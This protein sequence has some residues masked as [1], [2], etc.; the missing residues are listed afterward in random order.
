[1]RRSEVRPFE[2]RDRAWARELLTSRWGA[3]HVVARGRLH[4]ADLL[5]GLVARV[6]EVRGL[7]T[8]LLEAEECEIVTLDSEE[9]GLGLGAA[10][11]EAVT[12]LA[13]AAGCRQVVVMTTNDNTPALRFYQ[14]RGFR[15]AALHP[16]VVVE[17][18]ALKPEIPEVGLDGIPIRDEIELVHEL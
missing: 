7:L 5:P 6:G 10:L 15:L 8:Y 1:M 12:S 17:R 4:Q 11:I 13:R 2:K 9:S 14:R 16:D 3:P 18:R